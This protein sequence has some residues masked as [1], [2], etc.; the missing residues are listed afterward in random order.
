MIIQNKGM[1]IPE[2]LGEYGDLIIIFNIKMPTKI[3]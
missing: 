1:P 3:T 2:L